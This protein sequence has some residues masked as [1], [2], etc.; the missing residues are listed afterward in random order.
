MLSQ[1][2]EWTKTID[3]VEKQMTSQI[4]GF[5]KSKHDSKLSKKKFMDEVKKDVDKGLA[6]VKAAIGIGK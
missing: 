3:K 5:N 1:L 2:E 6:R 4:Q